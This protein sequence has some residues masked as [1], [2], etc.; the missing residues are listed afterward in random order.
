MDYGN[1]NDFLGLSNQHMAFSK[2]DQYFR[3]FVFWQTYVFIN[4]PGEEIFHGEIIGDIW[5]DLKSIFMRMNMS[6]FE[7]VGLNLIDVK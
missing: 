6:L 3:W 5:E 1:N 2:R 7:P 4:D